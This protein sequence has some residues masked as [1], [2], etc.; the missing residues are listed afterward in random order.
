MTAHVAPY[1][2]GT[3]LYG[4]PGYW[5]ARLVIKAYREDRLHE[6]DRSILMALAGRRRR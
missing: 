5:L 3:A 4:T 1:R 6:L 2:S